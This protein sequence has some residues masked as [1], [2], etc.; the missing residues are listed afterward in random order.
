MQKTVRQPLSTHEEKRR[1]LRRFRSSTLHPGSDTSLTGLLF[2]YVVRLVLFGIV[3]FAMGFYM[4]NKYFNGQG[5]RDGIKMELDRVLGV[6]ESTLRPF[7]WKDD[8]AVSVEYSA[9]GGPRAFFNDLKANRIRGRASWTDLLS[10][11]HWNIRDLGIGGLT[12]NLRSG[13]L[14]G[15]EQIEPS[16]PAP[17]SFFRATPD[18]S[19][20]PFRRLTID[21]LSAA[22]G[23]LWTAEGSLSD[24]VA[25]AVVEDGIWNMALTGGILR[26]NWLRD[27]QLA[28]LHVSVEPSRIV[29]KDGIFSLGKDGAGQLSG[30]IT[31]GARPAFDIDLSARS[32]T[33]EDLA[34]PHFGRF[35]TVGGD[36]ELDITGTTGAASGIETQGKL[37]V[38][39]G[40]IRNVFLFGTL[41]NLTNRPEIRTLLFDSGMLSFRT[42]EGQ[43]YVDDLSLV[44][45]GSLGG[46][47]IVLIN[48]SL[49][50]RTNAS[51]RTAGIE[52]GN[53]SSSGTASVGSSPAESVRR[54]ELNVDTP[55]DPSKL[56]EWIAGSLQ[57]DVLASLLETFPSLRDKY[58]RIEGDYA[59]I[60]V[61]LDGPV[62]S[63]S[64]ALARQIDDDIKLL[65]S[66][67]RFEE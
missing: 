63:C 3:V 4:C 42:A 57:I 5:F 7:R 6:S 9:Q 21:R 37:T 16:S 24:A 55:P 15:T 48:G 38:S 47:P 61:K 35:V 23:R 45:Q 67:T 59:R 41:A 62:D 22:W 64:D 25:E 28:S 18:F 19:H 39:G 56:E 65:V 50:Y 1:F 53:P 17:P 54:S 36:L 51:G 14:G 46:S 31:F 44:S 34:P 30:L 27:L 49:E 58:F 29:L 2:G 26:Q 8:Q 12:F 10:Q 66:R 33:L 52:A 13:A 60:E 11:R 20:I 43:L 40:R 32:V